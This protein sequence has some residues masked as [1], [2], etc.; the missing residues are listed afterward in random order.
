[1]RGVGYLLVDTAH[2]TL[3]TLG[4]THVVH[5]LMHVDNASRERSSRHHGTIF[6]RYDL[7]A[8]DLVVP[9]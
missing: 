2:R 6:R 4:Y 9:V 1:V 3:Q 5:A 7:M 8:L